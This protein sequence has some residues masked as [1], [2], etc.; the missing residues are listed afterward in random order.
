[1]NKILNNENIILKIK[2]IKLKI[3]NKIIVKLDVHLKNLILI[4]IYMI[5]WKKINKKIL[6]KRYNQKMM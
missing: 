5:Y 2:K 1:M 3:H 4:I 6:T